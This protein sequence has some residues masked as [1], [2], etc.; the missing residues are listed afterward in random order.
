M[1]QQKQPSEQMIS[2]V[3]TMYTLARLMDC[4]GM[5]FK[6]E[7]PTHYI[8]KKNDD[9]VRAAEKL[10]SSFDKKFA[11]EEQLEDTIDRVGAIGEV[12]EVLLSFDYESIK[13][14]KEALITNK[15]K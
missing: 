15:I 13:K 8:S 5:Q 12:I 9:V 6:N 10:Y 7:Y 3:K 2:T 4:Y 11:N 1:E 14:V